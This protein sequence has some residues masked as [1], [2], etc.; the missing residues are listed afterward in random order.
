MTLLQKTLAIT[1]NKPYQQVYTF[2][3]EPENFPLWADGLVQ[4]NFVYGDWTIQT[5]EGPATVRFSIRNSF[6]IVDHYVT[7]PSGREIYMPMRV[8][9]N[10]DG[11]EV[12]ITVYHQPD[13]TFDQFNNDLHLVERDLNKLKTLLEKED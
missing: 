5:P 12:I 10:D 3:A 4:L 11:A 1:I 13:M 9:E 6:G 8:I 7:L 2:L